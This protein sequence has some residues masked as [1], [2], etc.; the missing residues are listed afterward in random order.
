MT[1]DDGYGHGIDDVDWYDVVYKGSAFS[2]EHNAS[3]NGGSDKFNFYASVGYLDQDG[4]MNMGSD[5][6]KRYNGT[7]NSF[8]NAGTAESVNNASMIVVPYTWIGAGADN[9]WVTKNEYPYC[10]GYE[11]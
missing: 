10:Y 8:L 1:W 11:S 6:F 9:D 5:G 7:A 2:Q 3:V 4:F